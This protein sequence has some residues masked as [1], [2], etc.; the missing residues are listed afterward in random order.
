MVFQSESNI[1]RSMQYS[2]SKNNGW[3]WNSRWTH[4][5]LKTVGPGTENESCMEP[6]FSGPIDDD[7]ILRGVKALKRANVNTVLTE[8]LRGI[9]RFEHDGKTDAVIES[10][11]KATQACHRAGIKVIHHT[12]TTFSGHNL[13]EFPAAYREWLN[14]DAQTGTYA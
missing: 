2:G 8:G 6:T 7:E 4:W 1:M 9:I 12:T 10:I 5:W 3:L 13:S 14:I 11:R